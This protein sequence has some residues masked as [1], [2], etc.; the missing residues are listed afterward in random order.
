MSWTLSLQ[1]S[2]PSA[3][4]CSVC[5]FLRSLSQYHHPVNPPLGSALTT[6]SCFPRLWSLKR[7]T[8]KR[9]YFLHAIFSEYSWITGKRA[10]GQNSSATAK[11][12]TSWSA[13]LSTSVQKYLV[14][15][16]LFFSLHVL[17]SPPPPCYAEQDLLQVSRSCWWISSNFDFHRPWP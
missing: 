7:E 14:G 8:R 4:G 16:G 10:P 17:L 9:L 5:C 1:R 11:Q 12:G 3:S 2:M 15:L 13:Y 6:H